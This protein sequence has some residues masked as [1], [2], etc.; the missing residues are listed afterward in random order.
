MVN[1][2]M[3]S[4]GPSAAG[5][6]RN[7]QL[8]RGREVVTSVDLYEL[9][10][11]G[12]RSADR[13]LQADDVIFVGPVGPQV[14]VIGSVNQAAIFELKAG[15]TVND[16]LRMAGGLS[17]VA[18]TSRLAVERLDDRASVRITQIELP[19]GLATPLRSGDVLRAFNST[20]AALPV[21]RQNK[22]VRIEGEVLRPGEYVLPPQT[23][24]AD[25]LR[26]SGGLT[27]AAYVF[28]TEFSRESVR[29]TQQENYERALRPETEFAR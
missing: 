27:P 1:A 5:S 26:V 10:L 9:L 11:K 4:G 13:S 20:S 19:Q 14:A 8:R 18:D 16:L 2:L 29:V 24:I 28:G 22:R 3:R 21:Q 6:F 7:I 12:D 23:T 17:T 15:E 25:V